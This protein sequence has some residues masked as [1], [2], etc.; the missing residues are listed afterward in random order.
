[1]RNLIF[2]SHRIPY[3][4]DRGEKIRG[5]NLINHLARR[6]R[7]YL[8]CLIDDPA[9]A[10][11]VAYLR[12][13]CTEVA[14]FHIDKRL[15]KMK[16]LAHIRPGRPLMLDY[17]SHPGLQRWVN[18]TAA[19]NPMDVVY[20]FCTA[21]APYALNLDCSARILDMQD[22]DSEKWA[23]YARNSR[24]PARVVWQREARTLLRY[25]RHAVMQSD[26]AFLVTEEETRRFA[27]LA[28]ETS[29]KVT[30][31]QM[32][33][34][35]A[36]FSPAI[37]FANPYKGD[38]PHLVFTG[39]MDYWPNADAVT[40]FATEV[41]PS[42][43]DRLAEARFHIVGANPGLDVLRLAEQLGVHVTG[44]VPDVRPY[45]AHADVSV[46][47]LRMARGVQNKVLEAM[48]LGRPVVASPQ[49]FEGVRAV[50]GR[51]LLVADGADA[52]KGAIIDIIEGRHLGLGA[53]ARSLIEQT[54]TWDATLV[55]LDGFLDR[56]LQR[57]C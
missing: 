34:D 57:S 49:A 43:R 50:A 18:E 37:D 4:P 48:A 22:I 31:L 54:Y 23:D 35:V 6:Y 41:F 29:G 17:Y 52:M 11:H 19:S 1:V 53:A 20:I 3:P 25:E 30:W 2:I 21:M 45:V 39:N 9:D 28:P 12:T 16:A 26:L 44:R 56:L 40:W 24:W 51:D 47:P 5:Y 8:G 36:Q 27:E 38:G 15:Q 32:G 42:I 13:I 55:R 46:A 10:K 14:A 7:V 33:V